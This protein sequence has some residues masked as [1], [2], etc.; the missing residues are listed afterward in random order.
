[1]V[2]L[3]RDAYASFIRSEKLVAILFDAPAWDKGG[4]AVMEPLLRQ[5]A[6][7]LV[8]VAALGPAEREICHSIP[9]ANVPCVAYYRDGQLVAGLIGIGQDVVSRVKRWPLG[10]RS[11]T[12]MD[13]CFP[14][15]RLI[16]FATRRDFN[17][18][19]THPNQIQQGLFCGRF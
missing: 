15:P 6:T 10:N 7:E 17:V 2:R 5:A 16:G 3:T 1:V 12:R 14:T 8:E 13:A 19:S 4:W 18:P 11:A 9:V